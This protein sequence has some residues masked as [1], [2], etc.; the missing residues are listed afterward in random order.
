MRI[1][2]I[3]FV[4]IYMLFGAFLG[5]SALKWTENDQ[6]RRY[7]SEPASEHL[8]FFLFMTFLWFP[9][10]VGLGALAIASRPHKTG[11]HHA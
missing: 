7:I 10:F 5:Y 11:N 1:F 3:N 4:S 9:F 2:M 6:P 8:E